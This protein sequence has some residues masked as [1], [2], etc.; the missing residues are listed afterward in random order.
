MTDPLRRHRHRPGLRLDPRVSARRGARHR[1]EGHSRP[2]RGHEPHARGPRLV[3]LARHAHVRHG[4]DPG[5]RRGCGRRSPRPS[6]RS[7]RSTA[8]QLVVPRPQGRRAGRL[9]EG[10]AVRAGRR[11]RRG[12][13]RR[14]RVPRLVRAA[15]AR[16]QVQGRRRGP[17]AL[18]LVLRVRRR[19]HRGRGHRGDPPRRRVDRARHRP[20]AEPAARRRS[21][22]RLDLHGHR[23]GADGGAGLPSRPAQGAVA[24]R[25]QEPDDAGDAADPHDPRRDRR[26]RRARSA[27]RKRGRGRC[28]R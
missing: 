9:G 6:R 10:G 7:S 27:R 25:L 2:S 28:C 15:Q 14:A 21:G 4:G 22:R 18:L 5:G 20:R 16:G 8:A 26:S 12:D 17:I 13:A 24:A 3:L 1:A 19:A 23:R 11:A